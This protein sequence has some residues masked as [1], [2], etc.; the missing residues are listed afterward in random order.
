MNIRKLNESLSQLLEGDVVS[1]LDYKREKNANRRKE[2]SQEFV[3]QYGDELQ[4]F[5]I[6]EK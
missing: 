5:K 1:L 3:K 4:N 6:T 2:R